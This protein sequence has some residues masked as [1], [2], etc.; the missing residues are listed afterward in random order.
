MSRLFYFRKYGVLLNSFLLFLHSIGCFF[1][2]FSS[3]FNCLY[4][5]IMRCQY[6]VKNHRIIEYISETDCNLV[7]NS[8]CAVHCS[9][10]WAMCLVD[11]QFSQSW[12]SETYPV[13]TQMY[14]VMSIV[15]TVLCTVCCWGICSFPFVLGEFSKNA[16]SST[17]CTF[18]WAS[19][20]SVPYDT[21]RVRLPFLC[22]C[23]SWLLWHGLI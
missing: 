20:S 16:L 11:F 21:I 8:I 6:A 23:I 3:S 22:P 15:Y 10:V 9:S 4:D 7:T 14:C 17:W 13:L 12:D 5:M 1:W 18:P 19:A 2:T